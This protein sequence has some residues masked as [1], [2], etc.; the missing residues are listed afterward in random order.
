MDLTHIVI[1]EVLP[2]VNYLESIVLRTSDPPATPAT[3]LR[4]FEASRS[5]G[6][7]A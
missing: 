6:Y 1:D 4:L 3:P 2:E 5:R 7:D